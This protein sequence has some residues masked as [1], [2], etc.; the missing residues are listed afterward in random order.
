MSCLS[1]PYSGSRE[2]VAEVSAHPTPGKRRR[3]PEE[4]IFYSPIATVTP[5][6]T[7]WRPEK[8]CFGH[9]AHITPCK[10]SFELCVLPKRQRPR[11]AKSVRRSYT[12][13]T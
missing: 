5:K 7:L 3:L 6:V 2:V 8:V 1:I 12:F 10:D 11:W 4:S 9:L 13:L